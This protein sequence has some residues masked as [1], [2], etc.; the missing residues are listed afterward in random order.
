VDRQARLSRPGVVGE[1]IRFNP[2]ENELEEAIRMVDTR[3]QEAND[4]Y[5]HTALPEFVAGSSSS[6]FLRTACGSRGSVTEPQAATR[7][8][9][10]AR[11][12]T[13]RWRAYSAGSQI[14]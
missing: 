11:S 4:A 10:S 5:E 14:A 7:R 12:A 6:T 2:L 8:R 9:G 3:I 13:F 1:T